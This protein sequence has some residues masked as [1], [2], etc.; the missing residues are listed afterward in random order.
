MSR[1]I[2]VP[3]YPAALRYQQW[4]Y[5]EFP[6]QM[7]RHFDEVIRISGT[8]KHGEFSQS[9]PGQFSPIKA[10][11]DFECEQIQKYM[12]MKIYPDDI[13]FIAD[14]S[15]PGLFP[16]IL[17][18]K[19]PN[20]IFMFCHATSINVLDYYHKVSNS[21]WPIEAAH[22]RMCKKV[23]VGSNYHKIKLTW[24][25]AVV[26]YLP[27]PP[28]EPAQPQ[29]KSFN[30]VS[31]SRPN[32]QKVNEKLEKRV[33]DTFGTVHRKDV[34]SWDEY[35]DFLSQARCLLITSREDTFGYQI[36]DAVMNCCVP[37]APNKCA[38]PEL[39]PEEYLYKNE[40]D[41]L[42]KIKLAIDGKLGVPALNCDSNMILFYENIAREMKYDNKPF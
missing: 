25:N 39:L 8:L 18:H 24:N 10:A 32:P 34:K 16:N 29:N 15:F 2:F 12:N 23:F 1:L 5:H 22:A 6:K 19:K 4:W 26:T 14:L 38:Y 17:Y 20:K 13:L 40:E 33:V 11:I 27:Y 28:F 7:E 37:I 36:V 30:I 31:A 42:V 21:K 35:Y 41:M 3:Q 9:K